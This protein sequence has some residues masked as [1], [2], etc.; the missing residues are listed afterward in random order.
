MKRIILT[1]AGFENKRIEQVFLDMLKKKPKEARALWIPTAAIYEEA[2]KVLPECMEDLLNAGFLEENIFTYD[3][4][5]VLTYEELK[6]YDAIYVCGGDCRH[7]LDRMKEMGFIELLDPYVEDY[8][9]YLGVS[10]GSCICSKDFEDGIPW[11]P[12]EL[13]VHCKVGTPAGFY[14]P[15][16]MKRI[17]LTNDQAVIFEENKIRVVE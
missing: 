5:H 16:E 3:L 2:I 15:E 17:N 11:L 13:G 4:D 12:C 10:A 8:G 1:S 7:L 6:T 9:I 14:D